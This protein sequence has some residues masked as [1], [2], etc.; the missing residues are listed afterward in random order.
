MRKKWLTGVCLAAC[1]HVV[2]FEPTMFASKVD[3]TVDGYT[4][5]SE[6]QNFPVLVRISSSTIPEFR[7]SLFNTSDGSDIAFGDAEGN[8]YPHEIDTWNPD[9]ESLVWVRVPRLSGR[10]TAFTMYFGRADGGTGN[11][12]PSA[13]WSAYSAVWHLNADETTVGDSTGHGL[14]V[15]INASASAS[16]TPQGNDLLGSGYLLTTSGGNDR[17]ILD[18][19]LRFIDSMSD[20]DVTCHQ[21]TA[22]CWVKI[23]ATE[24][25]NTR[26]VLCCK[27]DYNNKTGFEF[28]KNGNGMMMRGSAAAGSVTPVATFKWKSEWTHFTGVF[29]GNYAWAYVNGESVLATTPAVAVKMTTDGVG[30][31]GVGGNSTQGYSCKG[32]YDEL[33]FFNGIPTDDWVKAEY[34]TVANRSFLT[35]GIIRNTAESVLQFS[36]RPT[37]VPSADGTSWLWS[38]EV[39]SGEGAVSAVFIDEAT[40]VAVTNLVDANVSGPEVVTHVPENLVPYA[41]YNWAAYGLSGNVERYFAANGR[42]YNGTLRV[43]AEGTANEGTGERARFVISR[44]AATAS[45][46]QPLVVNYEMSGTA[47]NGRTYV[48][49]PGEVVIPAGEAQATVA[50]I[51][52]LDYLMAEDAVVTLTISTLSLVV[53]ESSVSASV[54]IVNS[55]GGEYDATVRYLSTTGNDDWDGMTPETAK[56][57]LGAAIASLGADGGTVKVL[58]GTYVNETDAPTLYSLNTPVTVESLSGCAEDVVFTKG[59][60]SARIFQL[61]NDGARLRNI[62]VRDGG[63]VGEYACGGNIYLSSG[64][65]EG[66]VVSGGSSGNVEPDNWAVGG[67]NIYMTGGCVTRS[68]I[69]NGVSTTYK[70]YGTGVYMTGGQMDTSLIAWNRNDATD[71]GAVRMGAYAKMYNCTVVCNT[72]AYANGSPAFFFGNDEKNVRVYNT[73]VWNNTRSDGTPQIASRYLG[74]FCNCASDADVS[75]GV[76]C[77]QP[78]DFGFV[79]PD[80]GDFSLQLSSMLIDA[81]MSDEVTATLAVDLAGNA[82]P[83]GVALDVGAYECDSSSGYANV[84]A[85]SY[86]VLLPKDGVA[87][88]RFT[89]TVQG[90]EPQSLTWDF[91]DGTIVEN[92]S[93]ELTHGYAAYGE[94]LVRLR[95]ETTDGATFFSTLT[96][97]VSVHPATIYMA[98][99]GSSTLPYDTPEKGTAN[100]LTAIDFALPGSTI[101][102]GPGEYVSENEGKCD[103][104]KA[105]A[106]TGATGD[107]RDVVFRRGGAFYFRN[108]KVANEAALVSGVTF[109]G[110]RQE[111]YSG[112]SVYLVSGVVSNCI[113]RDCCLL[114]KDR[115]TLFG[116]V[117]MTGGVFTHSMVIGAGAVN[118]SSDET[119][120]NCVNGI[121][122]AIEGGLCSNCYIGGD[123]TAGFEESVRRCPGNLVYV[124]NSG[125]I[126]NCTIAGRRL[127]YDCM[128][129]SGVGLA[130]EKA[131]YVGPQASAVNCVVADMSYYSA[132]GDASEYAGL[133]P[134]LINDAKGRGLLASCAFDTIDAPNETCVRATAAQLFCD[135]STGDYRPN[136]AGP[137]VNAGSA[138]TLT[139]E[140]DLL[141]NRRVVGS[142]IDIGC[143]EMRNSGSVIF[144]R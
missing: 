12:D 114:N 119:V 98:V 35:S 144:L 95:V 49:L 127:R 48:R 3:F 136:P 24:V 46:A 23:D 53:E 32:E 5:S 118:S 17:L 87:E 64:T 84:V 61:Q 73:V 57:T 139:P 77:F 143:Y 4:G 94:Y 30:Y 44:D 13:V 62:T 52:Q 42:F 39:M 89:A 83:A 19:P 37:M 25:T 79:D 90:C 88:V 131:L 15:S 33:R 133:T 128:D 81:G 135:P 71:G 69:T 113:V 72:S 22:S 116:G 75:G 16:V 8:E 125:R 38:V 36:S 110:G 141:G 100:L 45:V 129:A 18:N 123:F 105:V 74:N 41:Q 7:Y 43:T 102:V 85:S 103:V 60:Q 80:N 9:G 140:V 86:E 132:F 1:L 124:A 50:V 56:A 93:L 40:G 10:E 59:Q 28:I 29:S 104:V 70:H 122:M 68:I 21:V 112:S 99:D 47:V 107:P 67:G 106:I 26:R 97:R 76:A 66:C 11:N 117:W 130:Q 138:T 51:P 82:R 63:F 134:M 111:G 108:I 65:V 6:L 137:L 27:G 91:G 121:A 2:A 109:A 14:K 34:D 54:T 20:D 101:V 126:E 31:G 120:I 78:E 92:A 96:K 115:Q 58:N 142:R 55:T